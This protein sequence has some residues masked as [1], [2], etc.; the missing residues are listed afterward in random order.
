MDPT[1]FISVGIVLYKV[2]L[3][4]H[5]PSSVHNRKAELFCVLKEYSLETELGKCL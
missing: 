5:S 3:E 1:M 4:E 2:I